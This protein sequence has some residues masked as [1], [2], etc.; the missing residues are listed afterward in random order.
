[1]L[2]AESVG[3]VVGTVES[4]QRAESELSVAVAQEFAEAL[5]A[6]IVRARS[7][8]A[9]AAASADL[10]G[11]ASALD[12]LEEAYGLARTSGVA[13]PR[14]GVRREETRS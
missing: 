8:L 4:F 7:R 1:M 3:A 13:V 6:R 11:I 9:E 2:P 10:V 12:E 14:P 5:V